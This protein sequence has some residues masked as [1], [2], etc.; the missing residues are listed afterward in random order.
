MGG[1]DSIS[2]CAGCDV[3]CLLVRIFGAFGGNFTIIIR[4]NFKVRFRDKQ[5]T[6]EP[7]FLP[8]I[9]HSRHSSYGK[10]FC[11]AQ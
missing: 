10:I 5:E 9:E 3:C 11:Q 7:E 2:V 1:R 6:A 8:N 4:L